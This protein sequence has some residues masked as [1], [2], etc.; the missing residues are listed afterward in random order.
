[1]GLRV[2]ASQ[3]GE[4]QFGHALATASQHSSGYDV[5]ATGAH[6]PT[7]PSGPVQGWRVSGAALAGSLD[8]E[9]GR[10]RLLLVGGIDGA[11]RRSADTAWLC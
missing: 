10:V 1:M 5:D 2:Q 8:G 3:P 6:L 4:A 11:G 9:S 7:F